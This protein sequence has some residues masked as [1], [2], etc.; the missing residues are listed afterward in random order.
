MISHPFGLLAFDQMAV[1][2]A[3]QRFARAGHQIVLAQLDDRRQAG[4][5]GVVL[6]RSS[7]S[8]PSRSACAMA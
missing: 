5:P 3:D 7:L 4:R 6:V 2:N 1:E 8:I